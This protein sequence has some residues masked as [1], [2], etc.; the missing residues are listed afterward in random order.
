MLPGIELAACA[1]LAVPVEVMRHVVR[2][3]SSFNP[4]A[5]G[6][7]GGRLVRQPRNRA[8]AVATAKMLEE[9]GFN[10]SLGIAQVNRHNLA[11]YGLD[12]YERA[13]DVCA[14]LQAGS[15]ILAECHDRAKGDWGKAL[16]CYYSGDFRT[17]FQH[18]YVQKVLATW[19]GAGQDPPGSD[20]VPLAG[21]GPSPTG[22]R[23][24]QAER[25]SLLERRIQGP[26]VAVDPEP[27]GVA[28]DVP[29]LATR[30]SVP[31]FP[32]EASGP[33]YL[34]PRG[35]PPMRPVAP[36]ADVVPPPA[37]PSPPTAGALQGNSATSTPTASRD[38]AFVF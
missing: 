2:V 16:S 8:E 22:Q 38:A 20:P 19:N 34:Q 5:I 29:Q 23:R 32:S 33:V 4:Y 15:K 27:G 26:A 7:V 6:V 24:G 10:F 30:N 1:D 13:F 25:A 36:A 18:G 37:H 31:A 21:S 35:A 28:I 12:S 11:P 9:R 3:E 17:G 14:N